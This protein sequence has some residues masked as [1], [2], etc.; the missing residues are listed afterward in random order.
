MCTSHLHLDSSY[1]GDRGS[2][3]IYINPGELKQLPFYTAIKD[4]STLQSMNLSPSADKEKFDLS[5]I[6][7]QL[8]D[9]MPTVSTISIP[10]L[11]RTCSDINTLARGDVIINIHGGSAVF[12]PATRI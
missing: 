2:K 12:D 7:Y 1:E 8:Q 10:Y 6:L 4:L 9:D 5:L 11:H 3:C